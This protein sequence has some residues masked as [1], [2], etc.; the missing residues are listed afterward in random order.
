MNH[1]HVVNRLLSKLELP[2]LDD[3]ANLVPVLAAQVRDHDHLRALIA[4]AEPEQRWNMYESLRPYLRFKAHELDW[5]I[6]EAKAV[7]EACRLP[8]WDSEKKA[9]IE[10]RPAPEI[11]TIQRAVEETL[12]AGRLHLT[13]RKCTFTETFCA[14]TSRKVDAI[15]KA[16]EAGWG[17]DATDK[18]E[19]CPKCMDVYGI[20]Y[21]NEP[22]DP[23][24]LVRRPKPNAVD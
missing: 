17:Y 19:M 11:K 8:E 18:F 4:K 5:Y 24:A 21:V 23:S 7:A 6:M 13:C 1:R 10:P 20:N 9:W 16:R 3:A 2:G 12:L 22:Y 15:D 14:S